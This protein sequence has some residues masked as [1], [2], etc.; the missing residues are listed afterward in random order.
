[1]NDDLLSYF[2]LPFFNVCRF[3]FFFFPVSTV[4]LNLSNFLYFDDPFNNLI[5]IEVINNNFLLFLFS[6]RFEI[7]VHIN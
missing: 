7:F 2:Y 5:I 6:N 3:W 4:N 1:M